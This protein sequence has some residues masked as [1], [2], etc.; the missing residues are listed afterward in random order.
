MGISN[1]DSGSCFVNK[2]ILTVS[3]SDSHSAATSNHHVVTPAEAG[4]QHGRWV[5][6]TSHRAPAIVGFPPTLG[7]GFRRDDGRMS[8]S[9]LHQSPFTSHQPRAF[10]A[11]AFLVALSI[12][13]IAPARAATISAASCSQG[14][15]QAAIDLAQNGD[16]VAVPA[17]ACTWTSVACQM[18]GNYCTPISIARSI[19][20]RGAGVAQTVISDGTEQAWNRPAIYVDGSSGAV[21]RITKMRF[22]GSGGGEGV[23][24]L[25]NCSQ[26][27]RVDGNQ[28]QTTGGRGITTS[29]FCRGLIDHNTFPNCSNEYIDVGGSNSQSWLEPIAAVLGTA[30]AVYVEDNYWSYDSSFAENGANTLDSNQGARWV[31]RYNK[32]DSWRN[33]QPLEAHGWTLA[34]NGVSG[35]RSVEIYRNQFNLLDPTYTAWNAIRIRGG[36]GVIYDNAFSGKW[37]TNEIRLDSER[38]RTTTSTNP[39]DCMS[40]NPADPS[41]W[42]APDRP[43]LYQI[44]NL[45]IWNNAVTNPPF[46]VLIQ[47]P[48]IVPFIVQDRDYFLRAPS[49]AVDRLGYVPYPY[50]HPMTLADYPGQQR[51]LD[52]GAVLDAGQVNLTWQTVTGAAS[53]RVVR[54]W[55]EAGAVV[56]A[57]TSRSE[58]PLQGFHV[59][60]VYALDGAGKIIAAEGKLL[61]TGPQPATGFVSVSPCRVLDTRISSGAAAAAPILAAQ[62]RRLFA[63]TGVCGVPNDAAAISAN[64]TVTSAQASGE[65]RV[66]GG[67]LVSTTT[68]ALSIPLTRARANNA[69]IQLATDGSGT[70]AVANDSGGTVHFVLDV[71]GYFR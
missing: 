2:G 14:D 35:T 60:M 42:E 13:G 8:F 65:M 24:L 58:T 69:I 29:G 50:P 31:Y 52:L 43:C 23:M 46:D 36:E 10:T 38:A 3:V 56:V 12:A 11:L 22:V 9:F 26:G 32:V 7:P 40:V 33:S 39:P 17:G 18:H 59:Y 25:R 16:T 49:R 53:Y 27:F 15:V 47:F 45:F 19:V 37:G 44:H 5:L 28:F 34:G 71:N 67:H 1:E 70:I 51:S 54:D 64:V 57:G 63:V 48:E 21:A 4:V 30:N 68:S 6:T 61:N 66:T 20:V 55:D 62:A 41:T